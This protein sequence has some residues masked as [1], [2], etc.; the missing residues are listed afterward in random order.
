MPVSAQPT[1]SPL[2]PSLQ[3][4]TNEHMRAPDGFAE[5]AFCMVPRSQHQ[6]SAFDDISFI[7]MILF[8]CQ[9]RRY[10]SDSLMLGLRSRLP[11]KE[12]KNP[13]TRKY[14]YEKNTKFPTQGRDPKMRKNQNTKWPKHDSF[15]IFSG[16]F[17]DFWVPPLSGG[18]CILSYFFCCFGFQEFLIFLPGKRDRN[19]WD[20]LPR[21][22]CPAPL[23]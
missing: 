1:T 6:H 22:I 2:T 12:P 11:G 15:R 19:S 4:Q 13:E 10:P 8:S 16:S 20:C 18:F 5:L 21:H 9:P 17:S 3:L 14:N 7:A 23:H